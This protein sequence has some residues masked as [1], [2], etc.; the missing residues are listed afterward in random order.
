MKRF[1]QTMGFFFAVSILL[2]VHATAQMGPLPT[3]AQ[4]YSQGF[5]KFIGM[6]LPDT[7]KAAYVKLDYFGPG[8]QGI[9]LDI[10]YEVQ[11]Q[12][13]AW[14]L[15]EDTSASS[16]LV[17]ASGVVLKLADAQTY[18]KRL[19]T[20]AL[21]NAETRTAADGSFLPAGSWKP[22]D[23]G[24]DLEKASVFVATK[25]QAK[26]VGG[27]KFS[28][29]FLRSDEGPGEM[30][31][32]AVLAWQ[33]GRTQEAN[34]LAGSLFEL[35]GDSRTVITGA[36]DVMADAQL[37]A[38][39]TA[40]R[41][42]HDWSTYQATVAALLEKYPVRWHKAGAARLLQKRLQARAVLETPP[43]IDGE[44]LDDESH[45]LAVALAME[46]AP[47]RT[48]GISEPLWFL[49]PAQPVRPG[50]KVGTV[51]RIKARGVRSIP[52]LLALA[53]DE[54]F[55]P[56]SREEVGISM[57]DSSWI[58][59]S[60][61]SDEARTQAY[62]QE[63]ERPL[64]RGE[65]ARHLLEPL[66]RPRQHH[67]G[68]EQTPKAITEA[69]QETYA[70]I[71]SLPPNEIAVYFMKN[72]TGDQKQAAIAALMTYGDETD[73]LLVETFLLTPAITGGDYGNTLVA[74]YVHIRGELAADFVER[75]AALRQQS[76]LATGMAEHEIVTLR[77][78]A[79]KPDVAKTIAVLVGAKSSDGNA[80]A[81]A[82]H[83]LSRLPIK[84]AL[85][86]VLGAAVQSTNAVVRTRLLQI[87]PMIRF[88]GFPEIMSETMEASV[89]A[90]AV[91]AA[92]AHNLTSIGTNAAAWEK[93]LADTRPAVSELA[94]FDG[95]YETTLAD[96]AAIA[97]EAL[98]AI[99]SPMDPTRRYR[100]FQGLPSQIS[101]RV[102]R[103]RATAR[104]AGTSEVDLPPIPSADDVTD[105]RR[106]AIIAIVTQATPQELPAIL[107]GFAAAENL[108]LA[109][110]VAEHAAVR[111][112]LTATERR[113]V[114]VRFD[115][116]LPDETV[117]RLKKLEGT[118]LTTNAIVAMRECCIQQLA[119]GTPV[120]VGLASVG[121]GQGLS[122][123]VKA[124]DA[125][126]QHRMAYAS[127][128]DALNR[129]SAKVQGMVWAMFQRGSGV[130]CPALWL[131]ELAPTATPA[132]AGAST[133]AA[134]ED[135]EDGSA[136][137]A[138]SM[139][140]AFTKMQQSF[141]NMAQDFCA[142]S[143]P[144]VG[145]TSITFIGIL[146]R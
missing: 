86:A 66:C 131:V 85:P 62:Y 30:F 105:E 13:N 51:D 27:G 6:G 19:E 25:L 80:V 69:A 34:A 114:S 119:S 72:G 146:P 92:A 17:T 90:A 58:D 83:A 129:K 2:G 32:L 120:H 53:A 1:Y 93:L 35:V 60:R 64:T 65:I 96:L 33:N 21:R 14:L 127:A 117:A 98:Y 109:Q 115:T 126:G 133:A 135:D 8:G 75:Y 82:Y 123:A 68:T 87:L 77:A 143:E 24:S 104:L 67:D 128:I 43:P 121:L 103:D 63:L 107:G 70:A 142:G 4:D 39:A 138:V 26:A 110:I 55:C 139:L 45:A 38:A 140:N 42:T 46:N 74:Q 47:D 29:D 71:R 136:D 99:E 44:G 15:A 76:E 3:A 97:M 116:V 112:A 59:D 23:L 50:A 28:D 101:M 118:T 91:Q 100:N 79:K 113:I 81:M 125:A 132:S 10:L 95:A 31:L 12:G 37:T 56:L 94:G 52:L 20:E 111:Q 54:T 36:M 84:T 108:Y 18:Y 122:L 5:R 61:Q 7:A 106:T 145:S 141:A 11:L 144:L 88:A 124:G 137:M 48:F 16:T 40:F 130:P 78:M 89:A 134:N 41:T 22:R 57:R 49:T 102:L 9:G 73:A